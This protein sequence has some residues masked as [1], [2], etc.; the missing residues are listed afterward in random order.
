MGQFSAEKPVPPGSALSGNQHK[1]LL[2][3]RRGSIGPRRRSP[4]PNARPA[5]GSPGTKGSIIK[6]ASCDGAFDCGTPIWL[7]QPN[8][9]DGKPRTTNTNTTTTPPNVDDLWSASKSS[10][11]R[12]RERP[13]ARQ[14]QDASRPGLANAMTIRR[15]ATCNQIGDAALIYAVEASR[16]PRPSAIFIQCGFEGSMS[17]RRSRADMVGRIVSGFAEAPAGPLVLSA[18]VSLLL[19]LTA[20]GLCLAQDDAAKAKRSIFIPLP[21]ERPSDITPGTPSIAAP[22][23][24]PPAPEAPPAPTANPVRAF[25]P[26]PAASRQQM[27]ACGLEWQKMKMDG[28]ARDKTWR[29]FADVCLSK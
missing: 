2:E 27:H 15:A 20:A 26:L 16:S 10:A 23:P 7:K 19:A 9:A 21:P 8:G 6:I 18:F 12:G 22:V 1:V 3:R 28:T 4:R 24:A 14:G 13:L 11:I 5:Y 29:D 17:G 25:R